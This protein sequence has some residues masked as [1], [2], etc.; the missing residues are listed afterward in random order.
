MLKTLPTM[1]IV[2]RITILTTQ[3]GSHHTPIPFKPFNVR[4]DSELTNCAESN[5]HRCREHPS[6]SGKHC[7]CLILRP[8]P[9]IFPFFSSL[10]PPFLSLFAPSC[11][12][13][14]PLS[15]YQKHSQ[16]HV[17]CVMVVWQLF[18]M[19]RTSMV[20]CSGYACVVATIFA[21]GLRV[22]FVLCFCSGVF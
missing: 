5:A 2:G 14:R 19:L 16:V 17:Q 7:W 22:L 6:T 10:F 8:P 12:P 20:V 3:S 13:L 1:L 21:L 11:A 4:S 18:Y 15:N 9:M